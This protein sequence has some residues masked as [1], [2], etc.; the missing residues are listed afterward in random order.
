MRYSPGTTRGASQLS[1]DVEN[2]PRN[3]AQLLTPPPLPRQVLLAPECASPICLRFRNR[4]SPSLL[5]PWLSLS[6]LSPKL[7]QS[8]P[9]ELQTQPKASRCPSQWPQMHPT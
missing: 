3:V 6:H 7:S 9:D 4:G 1:R 8:Q 2:L 5:Q